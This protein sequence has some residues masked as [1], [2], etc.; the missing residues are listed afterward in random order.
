MRENL[1]DDTYCLFAPSRIRNKEATFRGIQ[2]QN[3]ENRSSSAYFHFAV[4][5][6]AVIK[7]I[8]LGSPRLFIPMHAKTL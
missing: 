1:Q 2:L 6:K 7:K 8:L 3:Y 4:F 5:A